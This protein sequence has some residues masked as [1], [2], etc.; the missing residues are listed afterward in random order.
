MSVK[1]QVEVF[2]TELEAAKS[3]ET[4]MLH[5]VITQKTWS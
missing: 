2:T 1:V 5:V 4:A 3:S